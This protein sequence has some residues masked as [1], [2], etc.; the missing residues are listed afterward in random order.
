MPSICE[1]WEQIHETLNY[2]CNTNQTNH[3]KVQTKLLNF[4]WMGGPLQF[5][6]HSN[7]PLALHPDS[8]YNKPKA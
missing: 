7:L 4:P 2:F 8:L 1:Q 6:L 5:F 3:H